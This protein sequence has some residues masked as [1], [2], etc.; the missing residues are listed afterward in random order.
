[1]KELHKRRVQQLIDEVRSPNPVYDQSVRMLMR[2]LSNY[3]MFGIDVSSEKAKK[4][5]KR[6]SARANI[7]LKKIE[8]NNWH[9]HVINEHSYPL[10]SMWDWM[11]KEKNTLSIT[12]VWRKFENS[13]VTVTKEEDKALRLVDRQ[14]KLKKLSLTSKKRYKLAGIKIVTSKV[15]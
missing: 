14:A 7:L 6:M 15:K 12:K 4:L 1:M 2:V 8:F 9:G 3:A 10:K 13:M 11:L 5:N